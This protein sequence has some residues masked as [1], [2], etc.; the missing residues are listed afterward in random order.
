MP[1]KTLRQL[2]VGAVAAL[3]SVLAANPAAASLM[4]CALLSCGF[5]ATVTGVIDTPL[6]SPTF[7]GIVHAQAWQ[8]ASGVFTYVYDF[9]LD[10]GADNMFSI[11]VA[12]SG[13]QDLFDSSQNYGIVTDVTSG[14]VSA[15][16]LNPFGITS[17]HVLPLGLGPN[18]SPIDF[19][20]YA[21][22]TIEPGNGS[23]SVQGG[24]T[25]AFGGTLAPVPEPTTMLLL[26]TGMVW[27]GGRLYRQ[28]RKRLSH[29]RGPIAR[30]S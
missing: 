10:P 23:I 19:A 25:S 13:P 9:T 11:T 18:S 28:R 17:F 14:G 20:F 26:G 5:G 24:G 30:A 27:V 6:S 2:L 16:F 7:S 1:M 21:Q 29:C 8:N 3:T 4:D 22:S 12:S 15:M